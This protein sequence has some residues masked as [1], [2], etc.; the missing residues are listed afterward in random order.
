MTHREHYEDMQTDF[1]RRQKMHAHT[2]EYN[3]FASWIIVAVTFWAIVLMLAIAA[4]LVGG[5][6]EVQMSPRYG[7]TVD[8]ALNHARELDARCNPEDPN[9]IIDYEACRINSAHTTKALALIV[10]A[11]DGEADE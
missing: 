4:V 11:R 9:A 5:C 2:K 6:S 7:A 3:R 10:D 8:A 1:V